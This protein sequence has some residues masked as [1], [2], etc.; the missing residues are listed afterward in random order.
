MPVVSD[1]FCQTLPVTILP[2]SINSISSRHRVGVQTAGGAGGG[3]QVAAARGWAGGWKGALKFNK[4]E[5]KLVYGASSK[6]E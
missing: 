5:R 3:K 1:V 2:S 6:A 4:A